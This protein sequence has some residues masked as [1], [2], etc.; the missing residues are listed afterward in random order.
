M[1]IART[2]EEHEDASGLGATHQ[3]VTM[4]RCPS[5]GEDIKGRV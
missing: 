4:K 2:N 5:R 3:E 1:Q